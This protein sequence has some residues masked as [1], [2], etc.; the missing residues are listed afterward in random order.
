MA[1]LGALALAL[2]LALDG[3]SA[4][5]NSTG[6]AIVAAVSLVSGYVLL[7]GIWW[8]FF[9]DKSK[10]DGEDRGAVEPRPASSATDTRTGSPDGAVGSTAKPN[11]RD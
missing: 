9:R 2:P 11:R 6:I 1:A 10:W 4:T 8:F 5:G 7:A 3:E